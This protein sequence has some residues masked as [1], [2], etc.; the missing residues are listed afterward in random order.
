VAVLVRFATAAPVTHCR[1]AL[2]RPYSVPERLGLSGLAATAAAFGYPAVSSRTGLALPCPL[3]TL[4]G[5]PCPMCGMTTAATRVAEGHLSAA[6]A[7]NPFVLLLVGLTA[8]MSVLIAARSL[9]VAPLPAR[10]AAG[11]QRNVRCVVAVAFVL[12]WVF[13]LH[14]FGWV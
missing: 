8:V 11:R 4:T 5:V 1:A 9:G 14:R 3:R 12:S 2:A 13:Q 6:L 7:A 10:W